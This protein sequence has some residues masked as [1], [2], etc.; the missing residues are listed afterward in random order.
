MRPTLRQL[1]YIVA[2]ADTGRFSEAAQQLFVSQ[3]SLSA[4]V[5]EAE[6]HLGTMVFERNRSGVL[7]TPVGQEIVRRARYILRQVEEMKS[8][9]EHGGGGLY[10]QIKLGVLP[11]IGPYLLPRVTV[12]LHEEFPDLRLGIR[13]EAT[14]HLARRLVEG[15]LD[16]VVSTQED[17]PGMIAEPLFSE[18]LWIAVPPEDELAQNNGAVS[19]EALAGRPF[20]TLGLGHRLT[21]LVQGLAHRAGAHVSADYEGTSLDAI[22]HMAAMGSGI[23]ILPDLYVFCE[24]RRDDSVVFRRIEDLD[25]SREIS[26]IWRENS[27][28]DASFR[29]LARVLREGAEAILQSA[30]SASQS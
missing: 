4:Q 28:L 19:L 17:H 26:L 21:M 14:V 11:T 10:G 20:L 3:P 12:K 23:A 9:A 16:T 18:H 25:A 8:V 5:A 24:A 2:V 27:P 22:R 13:D 6:A 15:Q 29:A 1:Q 30:S 7:L